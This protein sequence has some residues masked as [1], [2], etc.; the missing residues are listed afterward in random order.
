MY[1]SSKNKNALLRLKKE[2]KI[3]CGV[4]TEK[5][6][7][8]SLSGYINN[9]VDVTYKMNECVTDTRQ[10]RTCSIT[11]NMVEKVQGVIGMLQDIIDGGVTLSQVDIGK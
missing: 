3:N 6:E 7:P 10:H 1:N 4:Q 11:Y 5:T 2:S 9:L 8:V